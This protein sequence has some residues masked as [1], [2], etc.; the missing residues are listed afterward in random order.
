MYILATKV[1]I[2]ST[3]DKIILKCDVIDRSVVNGIRESILFILFYI[4]HRV[5]KFFAS[6]EQDINKFYKSILNTLTFYL[7]DDDHKEVDF[8]GETLTFTLG[9]IKVSTTNGAF[10][11]LKLIIIVLVKNTTPVQKTLLVR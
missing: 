2:S 5:I 3:L 7:E 10:K 9:M 11:N 1:L 8:N 4:N 6:L